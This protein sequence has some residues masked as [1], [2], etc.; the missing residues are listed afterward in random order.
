MEAL[1]WAIESRQTDP[2]AKEGE[3]EG[4]V[5]TILIGLSNE[6]DGLVYELE[7]VQPPKSS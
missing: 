4:E 6:T 2:M 7:N 5:T 1:A 3:S